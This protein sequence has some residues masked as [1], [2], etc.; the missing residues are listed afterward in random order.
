M[1]FSEVLP[2]YV[3]CVSAMVMEGIP[4]RE[5]EMIVSYFSL[6]GK[7]PKNM[8]ECSAEYSVA[9]DEVDRIIHKWHPFLIKEYRNGKKL[10]NTL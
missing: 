10:T 3:P 8:I 5:L 1:N 9:L 6:S 2:K 4:P 7:P